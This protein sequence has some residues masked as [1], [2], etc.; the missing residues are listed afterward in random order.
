MAG[1]I[2]GFRWATSGHG[3]A[4][5]RMLLVSGAVVLLALFRGLIYFEKMEATIAD[6]V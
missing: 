3:P 1:V 2:T 6:V 5:G 4:P